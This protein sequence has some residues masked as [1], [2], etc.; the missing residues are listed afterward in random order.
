MVQTFLPYPDFVESAAVLD[1]KRLGKQRVEV[2]QILRALTREHYGWKRH[3]AVRMWVGFAEG[4][5]AYGEAICREW[6]ARGGADTVASSIAVDLATAGLPPVPRAQ[7]ELARVSA[8]PSW[9]GDERVH[10]SHRA[11][12]VRK[13]PEFYGALF[14]GA[15]PELPYFWP[16]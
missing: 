13:D 3:P 10:A 15:D 1:A 6:V 12:L 8:L 9:I 16:D 11:A 7:R 5:G 4:V 2:L 14:P